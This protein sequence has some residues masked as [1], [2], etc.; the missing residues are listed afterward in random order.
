M[1]L[2]YN[3]LDSLNTLMN[4][5]YKN[6]N[7]EVFNMQKLFD[8]N[9]KKTQIKLLKSIA[10]DYNLDYDELNNK[11][12]K[13]KLVDKIDQTNDNKEFILEKILINEKECFIENRFNGKIY[14]FKMEIIGEVKNNNFILFDK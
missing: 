3:N 10:K 4:H 1:D 6:F 7:E 8:K 5:F 9:N 2:E 12:I 11:Y 13:N 14:N